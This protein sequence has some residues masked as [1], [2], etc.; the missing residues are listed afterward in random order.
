MN[1]SFVIGF[2]VTVIR[3]GAVTDIRQRVSAPFEMKYLVVPAARAR[4]FEIV[5]VVVDGRVPFFAM[6]AS[7]AMFLPGTGGLQTESMRFGTCRPGGEIVVRV[8]NLTRRSLSFRCAVVGLT[9]KEPP[10]TVT[11]MQRAAQKRM[12]KM[13]GN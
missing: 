2:P 13:L 5:D 12:R 7:A 8:R 4:N 9:G 3:A 6:P 1:R 11:D 10:V